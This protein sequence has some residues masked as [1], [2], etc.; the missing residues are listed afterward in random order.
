MARRSC[1]ALSPKS[2]GKGLC[3]ALLAAGEGASLEV[4]APMG[5]LVSV[6]MEEGAVLNAEAGVKRVRI[7]GRFNGDG[8]IWR[9]SIGG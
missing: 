1:E 8:R 6:W 9:G 2:G 7:R 3:V 4:I 5:V